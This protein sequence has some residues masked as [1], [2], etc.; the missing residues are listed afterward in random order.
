MNTPKKNPQGT[1]KRFLVENFY[2]DDKKKSRLEIEETHID[3]FVVI[4][5]ISHEC[6]SYNFLLLSLMR[7]Y[8]DLR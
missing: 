7:I 4:N 1:L 6:L 2:K 5:I 8:R 3:D